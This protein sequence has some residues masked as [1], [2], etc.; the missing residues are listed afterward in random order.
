MARQ[1]SCNNGKSRAVRGPINIRLKLDVKQVGFFSLCLE[2][3]EYGRN[4]V[5]GVFVF[6]PLRAV[7]MV[8]L[9]F[10]QLPS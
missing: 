8:H 1:D 2:A 9:Y 5:L 4:G 10:P 7:E 6:L 3:M